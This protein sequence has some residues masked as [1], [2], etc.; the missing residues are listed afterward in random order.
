MYTEITKK[1]GNFSMDR[2]FDL[3]VEVVKEHLKSNG[4][5]YSITRCYLRCYHLLE[6][7]LDAQK[8]RYNS[9]LTEQW[10]QGI[11]DGMCG[12][13][14]KTYKC[15]LKKL[16]MAYHHEEIGDTRAQYEAL[17]NYQHLVPWCKDVLDTFLAE[18]CDEYDSHYIREIQNASARF[19]NYVTSRGLCGVEGIT[20]HLVADYYCD[21]EH[22]S[23]K[24]KDAYN[25]CVRKFLSYLSDEGLILSSVSLTLDKF[26]LPRLIFIGDLADGAR[27]VFTNLG[28]PSL[29]AV[30]FHEKTVEMEVVLQQHRYSKSIEKKF[31]K[32]WRE[33]FVFLEANSLAYSVDVALAWATHMRDYTIQWKSFRRAMMLFEQYRTNGGIDPRKVYTYKP[34]RT[35]ALPAWCKDDYMEYIKMKEREG[36]AKSTLDMHK[37]SC[38]R[39]ME[40]LNT[41]NIGSWDEVT[42]ETLKEFHRQDPHS[43]PEGKNAYSSKIRGFLDHLGNI[44]RVSPTLFL[45]VPSE[46]APRLSIVKTLT[47]S[48]ITDIYCYQDS[49][50]SSIELRDTAMILIGLRM[51][52]RA[53]DITSLR[54][55]DISWKQRVISVQQQKTCVFLKL[56]MPVEVGNAIYRYITRGR[57]D[58]DSE[59][60][61]VNHR[62][63]YDRMHPGVCRGA[64]LKALPNRTR[65]FHITRKTFASRMLVKDV[66]VGRIAETLGHV[67]NSSVMTYLST[68][69]DKMRLCALSLDRIP[70]KGGMMS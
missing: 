40:Y 38:C 32:A 41:I 28:T 52:L 48:D 19:L 10:L 30:E 67:D 34:D 3:A 14:V 59:F 43:T 12:S 60:V 20:H 5:S 66:A 7:S 27:N 22:G 37:S 4:Y 31:R 63:P 44:G 39:L 54:F 42:P 58:T 45:A 2:R 13:T 62:V 29:T 61:F 15:A 46:S 18:A 70:V 56:P 23:Y 51:G 53:S 49:A 50:D 16:N 35:E 1:G 17:Q 25:H 64:L 6:M 36:F 11:A 65:G 69:D 33:L 57:P 47:D 21:D 55:C 24:S 26:A 9:G 8:K 68:N